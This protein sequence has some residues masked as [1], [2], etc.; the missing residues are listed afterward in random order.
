M[1][2]VV[3][4]ITTVLKGMHTIHCATANR[5]SDYEIQPVKQPFRPMFY[6]FQLPST[7]QFFSH[8]CLKRLGLQF[9]AQ[10]NRGYSNP[11]YLILQENKIFL[12]VKKIKCCPLGYMLEVSGIKKLVVSLEGT[13]RLPSPD[14][15]QS[16][17]I[18]IFFV[19]CLFVLNH[20][21]DF[22][23][24]MVQRCCKN[25]LIYQIVS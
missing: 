7:V 12:N 11:G 2:P 13:P 25:G 15:N 17:F 19:T 14:V 1:A 9:T 24:S 20:S 6:N 5:S 3:T 18:V 23:Y 8:P 4:K 21:P 16:Y 10:I 22:F